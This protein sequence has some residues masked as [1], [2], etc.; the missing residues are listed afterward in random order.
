MVNFRNNKMLLLLQELPA[1]ATNLIIT[2]PRTS[3]IY[4]LPKPLNQ[5]CRVM[6]WQHASGRKNCVRYILTLLRRPNGALP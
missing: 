3:C 4:F 6:E 5:G 1:T 2:T